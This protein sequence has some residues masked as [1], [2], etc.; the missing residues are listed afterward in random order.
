[1]KFLHEAAHHF[2]VGVY[3][4]ANGHGTVL[5]SPT[6]LEKLEQVRMQRSF[7]C[8]VGG[9][10]AQLGVDFDP[11]GDAQPLVTWVRSSTPYPHQVQASSSAA[12]ELLLLSRAINQTVGDAISGVLLVEAVLRSDGVKCFM[13][14]LSQ[15]CIFELM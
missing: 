7:T 15:D 10:Y 12:R 13:P 3:W 14:H 2:D 1:M 6:L 9:G 11:A 8:K 4:E 5:F